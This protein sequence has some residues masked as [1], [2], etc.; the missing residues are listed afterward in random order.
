MASNDGWQS[1]TTDYE[2]ARARE[3]SLDRLMEWDAQRELI[4]SVAG[5]DL[6]DVGCGNGGKAIELAQRESDRAGTA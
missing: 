2:Q 3:D 5:K 1:L 4:G 6:L